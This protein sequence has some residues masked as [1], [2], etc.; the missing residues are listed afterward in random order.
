MPASCI[1]DSIFCFCI[2]MITAL[3]LVLSMT[4]IKG[5]AAEAPGFSCSLC[6]QRNLDSSTVGVP[7]MLFPERSIPD[8]AWTCKEVEES[9][10]SGLSLED[11]QDTIA[12]LPNHLIIDFAAF[13]GCDETNSIAEARMIDRR[14]SFCPESTT[15]TKLSSMAPSTYLSRLPPF[16]SPPTDAKEPS[17]SPAPTRSTRPSVSTT[18]GGL[19]HELTSLEPSFRSDGI[20][21]AGE[22][23]QSPP[24]ADSDTVFVDPCPDL[25]NIAP[26]VKDSDY[27]D[28]MIKPM[29]EFCCPSKGTDTPCS[30]CPPG[31]VMENPH[32]EI[33]IFNGDFSTDAGTCQDLQLELASVSVHS[34]EQAKTGCGFGTLDLPVFCGCSGVELSSHCP[35][36][37]PEDML[38]PDYDLSELLGYELTCEGAAGLAPSILADS[39]ICND[40]FHI[41]RKGCCQERH[42]CHM[43]PDGTDEI[44]FPDNIMS[45]NHRPQNCADFRFTL[46]F[47]DQD[48]CAELLS[49]FPVDFAS[50]CGCWGT[51]SPNECS[52][53]GERLEV[54]HDRPQDGFSE[55]DITCG[56]MEDLVQHITDPDLCAE[57][58]A[59]IRPKCCATKEAVVQP[60]SEVIEDVG[61]TISSELPMEDSQRTSDGYTEALFLYQLFAMF[62]LPHILIVLL[63]PAEVLEGIYEERDS[64]A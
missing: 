19:S 18:G 8:T 20:T 35:F 27:C 31:S 39:V 44:A 1:E 30:L 41:L 37:S 11:C 59:S 55:G 36:C 33:P 64:A 50:Y 22:T 61:A 42:R 45:L 60:G 28:T 38:N 56:E 7:T 3:A 9:I 16:V 58:Q 40:R 32:R 17:S 34:C 6:A 48:E 2:I 47:L 10:L 25:F 15:K 5:V 49:T 51:T 21:T 12:S 29:E 14:C 4:L 46:G 23:R 13:C 54:L 52:L 57:L 26:Y 43:C 63:A 62:V 53:C 24:G